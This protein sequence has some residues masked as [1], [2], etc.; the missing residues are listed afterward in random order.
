MPV[1]KCCWALGELLGLS[2]LVHLS[3]SF[4]SRSV[5]VSIFINI[6]HLS[7]PRGWIIQELEE[8]KE[9]LEAHLSW[10][11]SSNRR[12]AQ[13][14]FVGKVQCRHARKGGQFLPFRGKVLLQ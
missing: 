14:K 13:E 3:S 6:D 9:T 7:G 4:S 5:T 11:R 1:S 10:E 12:W 8:K 2:R